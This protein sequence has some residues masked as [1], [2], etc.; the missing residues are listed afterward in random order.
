LDL[1]I[2]PDSPRDDYD[3]MLFNATP[4][5]NELLESGRAQL[6]RSNNSRNDEFIKGKTGLKEGYSN[7]Y[8]EPG[9]G[10]SYSKSVEVKGGQKLALL[11]DNIYDAGSGFKFISWL[12]PAVSE[13]R[14]LTGTVRDKNTHA[15]IPAQIICED[16]STGAE[17]MRT[18]AGADG[19]YSMAIPADRAVNIVVQYSGYIF[20]T[21]DIEK[22]DSRAVI[23]FALAP[24]TEA[25]KL[26]LYNIHFTPD[27]DIISAASEPELLR[28]VSILQ[29]QKAWEIKI[30]GH[31][32]N[33]PFADARYLQKL[34]FNRAVA[35]KKYFTAGGIEAK[36]ITCIGVGG[37]SP[38]VITKDPVEGLRNLRVEIAFDKH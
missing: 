24:A 8:E 7:L 23:D 32:N 21:E 38:L 10:K 11:I 17:M 14:V 31:T 28:L 26:I 34:S 36:R 20:Q 27:R 30:I 1:D 19:A 33:N 25:D 2:I 16:D 13:T 9:P 15:P 4:D 37:K 29:Q 3:W 35:V 6:L 12:R 5:L 18:L 22:E